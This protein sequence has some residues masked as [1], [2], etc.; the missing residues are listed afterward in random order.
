[1]TLL[2]QFFVQGTGIAERRAAE[3]LIKADHQHIN[4]GEDAGAPFHGFFCSITHNFFISSSICHLRKANVSAFCANFKRPAKNI[5][6]ALDQN[7][8]ITNF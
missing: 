3:K 6:G 4:Y 1:M 8:N 5:F 2:Q 7:S